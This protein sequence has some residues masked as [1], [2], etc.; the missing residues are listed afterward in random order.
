MNITI[1]RPPRRLRKLSEPINPSDYSFTIP[2]NLTHLHIAPSP[3]LIQMQQ[4]APSAH[5]SRTPQDSRTPQQISFLQ[6]KTP[7][8]TFLMPPVEGGNRSKAA[9]Y[10]KLRFL[11]SF[12]DCLMQITKF[13]CMDTPQ[14]LQNYLLREPMGLTSTQYNFFYSIFAYVFILPFIAGYISDNIGVRKSLILFCVIQSIGHI[15]FMFGG[16]N[17][18]YWEMLVGRFIFGIGALCVEVCEDVLISVWYFDRELT[19]ALGLSFAS[20]RVGTA[21]TSVITPQVMDKNGVVC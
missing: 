21:T 19:M 14:A 10:A 11:I 12:C 13:Y 9:V 20:C 2:Q 1:S 5:E 15:I 18:N 8:Q 16:M 3:P 6:E 4:A 7:P 17:L